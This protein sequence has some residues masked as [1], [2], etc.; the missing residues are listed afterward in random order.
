MHLATSGRSLGNGLSKW[1]V[2]SF[3]G[4]PRP[5]GGKLTRSPRIQA[6]FFF[7]LTQHLQHVALVL[8]SQELDAPQ[9]PAGAPLVC[10]Q[11]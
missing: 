7:I 6:G 8:K 1:K 11:P 10:S 9:V 3:P 5:E 2:T 4:T